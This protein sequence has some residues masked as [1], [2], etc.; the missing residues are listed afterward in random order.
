M[1]HGLAGQQYCKSMNHYLDQLQRRK[2]S[3]S[4]KKTFDMI[5]E[6]HQFSEW[7]AIGIFLLYSSPLQDPSFIFMFAFCSTRNSMRRSV[8][9]IIRLCTII[10]LCQANYVTVH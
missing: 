9:N 8:R 6:G 2:A 3:P 7:R 1:F 4:Q 5:V 10:A